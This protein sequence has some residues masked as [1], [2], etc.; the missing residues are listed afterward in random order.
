MALKLPTAALDYSKL[1]LAQNQTRIRLH[2]TIGGVKDAL[3]TGGRVKRVQEPQHGVNAR[4]QPEHLPQAQQLK[5][6]RRK[7]SHG[8]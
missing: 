3:H 2:L 4:P 5:K 1:A 6:W 7:P 8:T